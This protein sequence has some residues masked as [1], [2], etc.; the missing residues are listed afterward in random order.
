MMQATF[1]VHPLLCHLL[2]VSNFGYLNNLSLCC[3]V[4][5]RPDERDQERES[6]R[7]KQVTTTTAMGK[8]E[9]TKVFFS[10]VLQ[11]SFSRRSRRGESREVDSPPARPF[12]A[13]CKA[14][15]IRLSTGRWTTGHCS[16]QQIGTGTSGLDGSER[17]CCARYV[18]MALYL[19]AKIVSVG[20]RETTDFDGLDTLAML[21]LENMSKMSR[22]WKN[23]RQSS[24]KINLPN[25]FYSMLKLNQEY[26]NMY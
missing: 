23:S 4:S 17:S 16:L 18:S 2:K 13:E 15:C 5:Q 10:C 3:L 19:A 26:I 24:K 7:G 20:V 8:K 12:C 22:K 9:S 21:G 11:K 1:V 14:A 6:E 25:Y